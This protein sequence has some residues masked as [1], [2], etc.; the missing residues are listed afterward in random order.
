MN[1]FLNTFFEGTTALRGARNLAVQLRTISVF[2]R[3]A[4]CITSQINYL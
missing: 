2:V 4:P 1:A 3:R